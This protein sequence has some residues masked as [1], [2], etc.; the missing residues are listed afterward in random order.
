MGVTG[1]NAEFTSPVAPARL[2]KALVIDLH[3]LL[4]QVVPK[5]V[6]SAVIVSGDGGVGSIKQYTFTEAVP[7]GFVKNRIDVL[8]K[9]SLV[10]KYTMIDGDDIGKKLKS[11]TY[12]IK[13]E[14]CG[15]GGS[16]CKLTAELDAIE[17]VK[18]TQEQLNLEKDGML[19]TYKAVEA[20][21][22]AN[23]TVCAA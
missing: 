2:F 17:G 5:E 13:V 20:Y 21:L 16:V 22:L 23:P 18:Y 12:Q 14:A 19:G 15:N 9:D 10:S 11:A 8:D 3:H 1:Y 4:P 6:K 7:Y